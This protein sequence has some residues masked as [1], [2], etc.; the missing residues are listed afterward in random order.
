MLLI[1]LIGGAAT[2]HLKKTRPPKKEKGRDTLRAAK[3]RCRQGPTRQIERGSK[4]VR[5]QLRNEK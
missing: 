4:K 3:N 5:R 2:G 1:T